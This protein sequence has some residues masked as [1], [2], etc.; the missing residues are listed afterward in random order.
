M[1]LASNIDFLRRFQKAGQND[2]PE[3]TLRAYSPTGRPINVL[4]SVEDFGSNPG[5][6]RMLCFVP[7]RLGSRPALVVALHGCGQDPVAYDVGAGW[8]VLAERFG[9]ALLMPGQTTAN[10]AHTCF[11]W[12][13]PD[14]TMRGGG[15]ALSIRQMIAA[16]V[17]RH[18]IDP[19]RIFI[20]GLSAGGAMANT[21]LATY[22][23]LFAA[24]AIIAGLPYGV[25]SNVQQALG[26]MMK[27]RA[28]SA[29]ALGDLVR[30]AS[31]HRGPWPRI[32]I[33][34][35]DADR[36][37]HPANARELAKQWL[38]VHHLPQA[39]MSQT[40]V[41]GYPRRI[42]W[43]RD[44]ATAVETYSIT[45]MG[46]G[47]PLGLGADDLPC[48]MQGPFMLEA[49]IS[50]TCHIATF[51]GLT[52]RIDDRT[53]SRDVVTPPEQPYREPVIDILAPL[54]RA[55]AADQSLQ[56]RPVDVGRIINRALTAAGLI[57]R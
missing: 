2:P 44:G 51:F 39:P 46:H 55:R 7:D 8:S 52:T 20:T 23:E 4:R 13:N 11:N 14:D 47:T 19:E 15:E 41:D 32:S 30:K 5:N 3:Q 35:G 27:P 56:R 37:V 53:A 48:G 38:D 25:A 24:G 33:W 54:A 57:K 1:S 10:N 49:G 28:H 36:T 50:S 21:M 29:R 22:P 17:E 40:L 9:F 18:R 26:T 6:L 45:G 31:P 43:D 12:F 34:Q 16:M 42:W